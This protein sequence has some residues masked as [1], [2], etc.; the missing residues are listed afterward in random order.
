[1]TLLRSLRA[2]ALMGRLFASRS[3]PDP[4][5]LYARLRSL[6]PVRLAP[7]GLW[8]LSRY[9][10]VS[11][12]VHHPVVSSEGRTKLFELFFRG[13]SESLR[14]TMLFRDPPDHTRLRR[15]VSK[16]FTPRVVEELR[17]RVQEIAD[18]LLD[19]SADRATIDLLADF[20]HPL[21]LI[22][23]CE[24]LGVPP[25]DRDR[26][27]RHVVAIAK[28]FNPTPS[29]ML[30]RRTAQRGQEAARD[31]EQYFRALIAERRERPGDDLLTALVAAEDDGARLSEDEIVAMCALLLVAGHETTANLVG[32]GMVALLRHPDQLARLRH[33]PSVI[34]SAV[35]EFLRY[36]TPAQMIVR[37]VGGDIE[38]NGTT[39]KQG[40]LVLVM[41]GAANRDPAQFRDP[42]RLDIARQN[43]RHLAFATGLHYCL[44][45]PLARLEAQVAFTTLTRRLIDMRLG[46]DHPTWRNTI[47]LRGLQSFPLAFSEV[48][49]SS[50]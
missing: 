39:I 20:A 47:A 8:V 6:G 5:P 2:E 21:P 9:D 11:A 29:V 43:N 35:E 27:A 23:I 45:A 12:L 17:P 15:L 32:N 22:V 7:L 42:E 3:R 44:G 30:S 13:E 50:S 49:R 40:E 25:R 14:T 4:Y 33:D 26:F 10:D 19:A 28:R 48:V 24:L 37:T 31:L 34:D 18:G 36:D 38:L 46:V 16:A 1:M 41:L